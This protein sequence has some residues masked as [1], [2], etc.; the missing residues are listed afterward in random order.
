M[1]KF[2]LKRQT[3]VDGKGIEIEGEISPEIRQM[4]E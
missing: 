2:I 4:V 1:K 3:I